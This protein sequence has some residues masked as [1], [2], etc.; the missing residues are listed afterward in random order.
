MKH[1]VLCT[2]PFMRFPRV[3]A[4][5]QE[6][7]DGEVVEYMAHDQMIRNIAKFEGLIPNAR[8]AV[9]SK[10]LNNAKLLRAIYQPSIGYE[11]INLE[12][13]ESK[14]IIFNGLGLDLKF[15][16]TLWST[17]E[18]TL[19]M[20][21]ALLKSSIRSMED[22]KSTGAWDNRKYFIRDLR[23]LDVGIIGLGNIGSKVAHLCNAFGAKILAHDPYLEE[24]DFPDYVTKVSLATL[25][26]QSDVITIHVPSNSETRNMIASKEI[27]N[28]KKDAYFLNVARGGIVCEKTLLNALE[29]DRIAGVALDV[30]NGE[31]PF[32]VADHPLVKFSVGRS[33]VLIT[34]HLGGSSYTY[35]ESIFLHSIDELKT[36]LDKG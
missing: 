2:A 13:A 18:H 12:I 11:H 35:M 3:M 32:G 34:P 33:N 25:M 6:L 30:L 17:A 5:F 21:L 27:F 14:S 28:M 1:K 22:V 29:N 4:H 24:T 36:M 10:V 19:S 23:G 16:S 9:D 26:A 31:S 20:I 7:F 15:K 8:I